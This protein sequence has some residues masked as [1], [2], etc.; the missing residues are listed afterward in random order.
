M[1]EI[2][3][4]LEDFNSSKRYKITMYIIFFFFKFLFKKT[5]Q[6]TRNIIL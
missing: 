6:L 5:W 4:S 2:K 1:N 3:G